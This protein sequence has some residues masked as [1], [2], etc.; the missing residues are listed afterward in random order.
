MTDCY[1]ILGVP[2]TAT[3]DEIKK[4]YRKLANQHHPDKGGDT[5]KFQEI[6]S[7]YDKIGDEQSRAQYDAE[8]KGMGGFRFNVNGNDM[9]GHPDMEEMLRSFGFSFG[10]FQQ[11]DPFSGFRQPRRNKDVQV[12]ILVSLASTLEEQTKSISIQNTNGERYPVNVTIPRGVRSGSRIKYPNLGDNL[13]DTL[14]R[15]DLYVGI[16]IEP[17]KDFHV[18]GIDLI[19]VV[20]I[21]CVSAM[22]GTELEVSGID[23]KKFL[24]NIPSGT[25]PN[26]KLR[27]SGQGLYEMNQN[28]RGNLIVH[29][30]ISVP[31]DITEHQRTT[32]RELF[33]NQPK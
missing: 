3:Q 22:V 25:Q 6:Q 2:E 31:K 10:G 21:D 8:R 15:G 12:N 23:G 19:K 4:A 14:P 30:T 27:I 7:A 5:S 29:V 33:L 32:L 16:H 9:S 20:D 1:K 11:G 24:V 17:S 18:D 13:F 28:H 26:T